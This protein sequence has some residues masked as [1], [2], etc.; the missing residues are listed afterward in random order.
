MK[1]LRLFGGSKPF[2]SSLSLC[3]QT[4]I[5]TT[6]SFRLAYSSPPVS[7]ML[8]PL[9]LFDDMPTF[10]FSPHFIFLHPMTA[11]HKSVASPHCNILHGHVCPTNSLPCLLLNLLY[12]QT[13]FRPNICP[14]TF[15]YFI[16]LLYVAPF[17]HISANW[18]HILMYTHS[19]SPLFRLMN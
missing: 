6:L 19:M 2:M 1:R 15:L 16:L 7:L 3:P 13:F 5:L 11:K 9:T 14:L 10:S 8:S 4:H 17:L 12:H 18:A